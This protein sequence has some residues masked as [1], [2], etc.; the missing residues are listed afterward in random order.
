MTSLHIRRSAAWAFALLLMSAL[1]WL[2]HVS[3][4]RAA[5]SRSAESDAAFRRDVKP[6]FDKHCAQCHNADA[7]IA[8]VRVDHL[9]AAMADETVHLWEGIRRRVANDTMPPKELPRPDEAE[10]RKAVAWMDQMLE[11]ARLRPTPKN[12]AVRRLTVAQYRNTLQELLLI[13]DKLTEALPPDAVS[14]DGFVNNTETLQLSPL[15]MEAYFEIAEEA[16]RRA[17]V[18]SETPPA[19][20]SFRMDLGAGVNPDPLPEQLILGANSLLLEN[21]DFVVTQLVPKKPFAFEPFFMQTQYR[22]IEGYQGNDTVRGWRNFDSI[23]HAVFACMRGSRGYP[24]GLPYD[25]VPEGLLLRPAIPT[26]ELFG[27]DGTYGP[28]ANFKIALRELPD[29]G[30]FRVTVTAAK[31]NDGL[32]LDEGDEAQPEGAAAVVA[33]KPK[34]GATVRIGKTGLYQV[35]LHTAADGPATATPDGSRLSAGLAGYWPLEGEAYSQLQG[36]ATLVRSPFGRAV[37][38]EGPGD[39]VTAAA[40]DAINI[41]EG[42]FTVSAWIK[43]GVLK[44]GGIVAR[45]GYDWTHGWYLDMPDNKGVLRLETFG[46]DKESN[47]VVTSQPG[48]IVEGAWHHV[49]AI[50]RR[51]QDGARLYVN[52]YPVA[53]GD[54]GPADLDNPNLDLHMGRIPEGPQFRGDIDEVRLYRRALEEAE[55]QALIEPGR[56]F[57][58]PPAE[59]PQDVRLSLGGRQFSAKLERPAFLALR[60]EAGELPVRAEYAGVK[61]LERVVFTPL[62]DE[63][64]VAARFLAF[65]KRSP[66][67]GVHVGLRRDCGHSFGPVGE[68]QTVSNGSLERFVFEGAIANFPNPHVEAD[69]V[70]Y[71]AGIR[72]IAVRSEYT[73]GR[74]MPRLT[75]RS[76]EFE[77]PYYETWPPPSHASIFIDSPNR[78]NPALYAREILR[79]FAG[80]AYRRPPSTDEV[81]ALAA[82]FDRSFA[83]S[84]HFR[85]S[86]TDALQVALTSPQFLFLVE[87]SLTPEPEPLDDYELASKLSYFLWNGPP[88]EKTLEIAASGDLRGRLDSEVDRMIDDPRFS[89]FTHELVSQWLSLDKLDVL[90]PDREKFPRLTR[91]VRAEL[92][93]EPIELMRR[94]IRENL[95]VRLLVDSDFV[96]A[97]EVVAD[98]YGFPE[99]TESGFEFVPIAHG[100][101]ELGGLLTQAGIMAGLSD[102]RESN[103]VK[104]GAWLARKIVAEPP[105]DPPPNVPALDEEAEGLTLRERLEQH[106]SAP[107]CMQCH[108]KIDPWGVPFEEID[109]AGRLKAEPVDARSALPDG[110]EV[111]G[112]NGLKRYLAEDR[113]DQVAFS[114]LK[115]LFTYA[116]G[117]SLSFSEAHALKEDA[118]SLRADGYRMRDMLRYVVR[119]DLFL[120]K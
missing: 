45:G 36:A 79:N 120:E 15:L 74:D 81:A 91:E 10:R 96:V 116:N 117:R 32:L 21:P 12:G 57:A 7:N 63:S 103:P 48:V 13:G 68:P 99:K 85:E 58:L 88:D 22:F 47:G 71:L 38:L 80:R 66:R 31:Y 102:G 92:R 111:S 33:H 16:L 8:G 67:L 110:T 25:T 6:F 90:E 104:R 2:H 27:S 77:G 105:S 34:E 41:G 95:P 61:D 83:E 119:S 118:K 44:R 56:R 26:D 43:P 42:D 115:H 18:D 60:L 46:A 84:G 59:K 73:D 78:D 1:A 69:N 86:V 100:R 20:Q 17:I 55:L 72:E 106:R 35:D 14:K 89:R 3:P 62:A 93:R 76:I 112:V 53:K 107:G 49:A 50:V 4:A 97:N 113:I 28:K 108:L 24:K 29:Y 101:P 82:V 94:L 39:S 40:G 54:I 64:P 30:P 98:Y 5:D 114:V 52:G 23:Y 9:D 65:E 75:V 37:S 51:G 19:I 70:N 109:A 87:N 11:V